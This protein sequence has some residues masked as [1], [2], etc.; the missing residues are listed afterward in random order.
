MNQGKRL[1]FRVV[2]QTL[3]DKSTGWADARETLGLKKGSNDR[4]RSRGRRADEEA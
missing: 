3:A 2:N 4:A 1:S